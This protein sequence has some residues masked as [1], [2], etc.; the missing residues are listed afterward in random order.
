MAIRFNVKQ[1]L[2]PKILINIGAC[3]DIP[4]GAI[5]TGAKGE[6]IINGGL[7]IITAVVG[8]GNNFKSTIMHYMML[9]AA[10]RIMSTRETGMMTYDTEIN[11]TPDRLPRL[12]EKMEYI[13]KN[14]LFDPDNGLWAITDKR[15]YYADE[16]M[17]VLRE[18][19][20]EKVKDK[21]ALMDLQPFTDKSSKPLK[22]P[23]PTF[24][25]VDS[26]SEFED[27]NTIEM[28]DK[29]SLGDSST[30]TLFMKQGLTKAKFLM[31]LPRISNSSNTYF[32]ISAQVGKDINMQTG[33]I[34]QAPT[35]KLQYL[36]GGDKVKG[37]SD[38]FFFLMSNA[39]HAYNAAPLIN[40]GTKLPE[41]PISAAASQ[42]PTE[43]NVVKLTQ[44]RSKSGPTGYTLDILVSQTE[45]VLPSLTEFHHIK[46]NKRYGLEGNDRNYHMA[47]YPDVNL[48]RTTVRSKLDNDPKLRRAMNITSEMCQMQKFWP[49]LIDDGLLCTPQELYEDIKKLGYDWDILLET[50]GWWSPD[51]YEHPVPFLSSMD[52][53][54]M[55]KKL[56]KPYW[57]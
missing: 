51:Q 41:Y 22:M 29:N 16:W 2:N 46:T 45:G 19:I 12:V 14:E 9:Q 36:K 35:K 39:W 32:L 27:K 3:L 10:N 37:V 55:R 26:L 18:Y 34:H 1:T 21:K 56:Y 50:R 6:S 57:L 24:I 38:K 49:Y 8:I 28:A 11:M 25:E 20:K 4:T 43:L 42:D 7:G 44:L 15:E 30:N 5:I 23:V 54:K 17:N 53:L 13:N 33:P 47:L 31:E 40:Q 48:S 52:L